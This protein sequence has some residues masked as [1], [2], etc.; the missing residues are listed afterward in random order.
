LI[1]EVSA[2]GGLLASSTRTSGGIVLLRLS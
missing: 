2:L 1:S